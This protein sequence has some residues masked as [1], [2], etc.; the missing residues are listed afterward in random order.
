MKTIR[1]LLL[2]VGTALFLAACGTGGNGG[3]DDAQE[4]T[5]RFALNG[6]DRAAVEV[7]SGDTSV[8]DDVVDDGDTTDLAAGD[9]RVVGG[10][11]SGYNAPS[12]VNVTVVAGETVTATLNY[13]ADGADN[14]DNGDGGDTDPVTDPGLY[15]SLNPFS[16][17]DADTT[18]TVTDYDSG[19]VVAAS[20]GAGD[21]FYPL[22]KEGLY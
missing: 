7:F 17:R 18:I 20:S 11:V 1:N 3:G 5:L 12:A 4:G 14:G 13:T 15:V 19:D 21:L 22:E 6:V 16:V 8:F 9:Y 10:A 2:F